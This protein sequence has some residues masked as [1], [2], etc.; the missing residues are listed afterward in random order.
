[1]KGFSAYQRNSQFRSK[2]LGT[3]SS[4]NEYIAFRAEHGID[5][6]SYKDL[7]LGDYFTIQDGTYNVQWMV[8]HFNYYQRKGDTDN[9]S[10]VVLIPRVSCG[11]SKMNN[12]TPST[13]AGGY[14]SSIANTTTCPAIATALQ[15]VLGSYLLTT[16]L[17][18]STN[19][20]T[21]YASM[22]GVNWTG[23]SSSWAWTATQCSLPN[24]VQIFGT[25]IASSSLYDIGEANEKLAVF[26][27]I[28]HVEY[29]RS[30]FWLR[31]VASSAYFVY[32]T[33]NGYVSATNSTATH[34]LRPLIYIG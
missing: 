1:M 19:V 33:N 17:H 6:R 21:N 32:A 28:N 7:Y 2:N 30:S 24:E 9:A 31:S 20:N 13:T 27:F 22:A 34:P 8:A 16:K 14:V 15:N 10:G 3:I 18:M 25:T 12:V 5:D 4:L 23:G 29:T 11:E 26:N